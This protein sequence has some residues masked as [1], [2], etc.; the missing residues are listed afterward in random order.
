MLAQQCT[1]A[2][3]EAGDLK[4]DGARQEN[5]NLLNIPPPKGRWTPPPS[6][7][8]KA[9]SVMLPSCPVQIIRRTTVRSQTLPCCAALLPS[10]AAVALSQVPVH[11]ASTTVYT[12]QA[13]DL[14]RGA[15]G[16][17]E[18]NRLPNQR[19]DQNTQAQCI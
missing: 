1:Q 9:L 14:M 15:A 2:M 16:A 19:P 11:D 10:A 17:L 7:H 13:G 3:L 5:C 6:N 12:C 8:C 18:R 4:S